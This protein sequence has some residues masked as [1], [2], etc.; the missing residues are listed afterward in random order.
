[1]IRVNNLRKVTA[2]ACLSAAG[3]L[4]AF[5]QNTDINSILNGVLTKVK[6]A[7]MPIVD[8]VLITIGTIGVIMCIPATIKYLRGDPTASDIFL[9]IG[10]GIV[11]VVGLVEVI[12]QYLL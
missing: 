10:G 12:R 5:A 3:V 2:T 9:K 8:I 6:S 11:I 1:M 4:N 7:G